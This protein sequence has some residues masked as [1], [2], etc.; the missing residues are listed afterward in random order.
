MVSPL[1]DMYTTHHKGGRRKGFSILETDRGELFRILVGEGKQVLDIGCRDGTLTRYFIK[2]NTVLGID[3]DTVL[4]KEAHENLG[5][6]TATFDLNGSWS[7]VSGRTFSA[8]V[9][10]EVLEHLFFPSEIC[11]KVRAVLEIEGVF[12]GSVPN[13]FTLKHRLRYLFASKA[14][15]PLSDPTHINHF[16][17]HELRAM[18]LKHFDEVTIYGLGRYTFLSRYF[19]SLFAFDLVFCA[20]VR[21]VR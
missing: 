20:K 7:D 16:S 14:H 21:A 1:E 18:L 2:G 9:A 12:V 5:I 19:P 4:L 10:G 17:V 13:A 8:V 6:E 15:T 3:I 11:K